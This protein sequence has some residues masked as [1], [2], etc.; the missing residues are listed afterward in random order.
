[1]T[2]VPACAMQDTLGNI[3]GGIAIQMDNSIQ[4]G[5]WIRVDDKVGRMVDIRWRSTS[6][7]TRD[8]E[9]VV[10]PN[11]KLMKGIFSVLGRRLGEPTQGRRH[12]RFAVEL[13]APPT[14]VIPAIEQ[15][16][17][18]SEIAHTARIP[19]PNCVLMNF[20]HRYGVYDLR[21]WLTDLRYDDP[22]D[23]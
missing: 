4:L 5:H 2:A 9:T 7:E 16:N 22:T 1:M 14:R 12:V 18:E 20:E 19:A 3:Q 6:I 15:A 8:W 21:Y 17:R 11:S 23:S 13:S 10:L